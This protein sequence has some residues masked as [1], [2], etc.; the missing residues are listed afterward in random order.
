[1]NILENVSIKYDNEFILKNVNIKFNE[2]NIIHLIGPNGVGKTS[3]CQS[4]IGKNIFEGKININQEEIGIAT[5]D[6]QIPNDLTIKQIFDYIG[7]DNIEDYF[8]NYFEYNLLKKRINQLSSGQQKMVNLAIVFNKKNNLIILDEITTNLDQKN[9]KIILELIKELANKKKIIYVTHN[10][11]E[12]IELGGQK[13]FY[14]DKTFIEKNV[15]EEKE[16]KELYLNMYGEL[17]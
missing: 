13:Y 9:K 2:K 17:K 5:Q 11:N 12:I 10:L 15:I 14:H 7:I 8:I 1:M 16:I 3:L 6:F 4:I